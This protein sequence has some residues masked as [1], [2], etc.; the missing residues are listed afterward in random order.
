[1][2][3]VWNKVFLVQ[4]VLLV[5]PTILDNHFVIK[6]SYGF[7]AEGFLEDTFKS[8]KKHTSDAVDFIMEDFNILG[9]PEKKTRNDMYYTI[10]EIQKELS[11][12][13]YLHDRPDGIY[14]PKTKSAI[15]HFQQ[16]RNLPL[17]GNPSKELLYTLQS[18]PTHRSNEDDGSIKITRKPIQY[19]DR[20]SASTETSFT[21]IS[22]PSNGLIIHDRP[23]SKEH[24]RLLI[25]MV[26]RKFPEAKSSKDF[27]ES[28]VLTEPEYIQSRYFGKYGWKGNHMFEKEDSMKAYLHEH[29]VPYL[30]TLPELPIHYTSVA[31]VNLSDYREKDGGFPIQGVR[32]GPQFGTI[33]PYVNWQLPSIYPADKNQARAFLD[34]LEAQDHHVSAHS[35]FM[36]KFYF[37]V[38]AQLNDIKPIKEKRLGKEYNARYELIVKP[39]NMNLYAD[40]DL[41]KHVGGFPLENSLESTMQLAQTDSGFS[42]LLSPPG[43]IAPI[44]LPF[45]NGYPVFGEFFKRNHANL[46]HSKSHQRKFGQIEEGKKSAYRVNLGKYLDLLAIAD[47]PEALTVQDMEGKIKQ[48]AKPEKRHVSPSKEITQAE[49]LLYIKAKYLSDRKR[50][51]HI[52]YFPNY[53]EDGF[54]RGFIGKNIFEKEDNMMQIHQFLDLLTLETMGK[55]LP[56]RILHISTVGLKYN[57][58]KKGFDVTGRLPNGQMDDFCSN[59]NC[60]ISTALNVNLVKPDTIYRPVPDFFPME[61]LEARK[62]SSKLQ[63]EN[64]PYLKRD[65][66]LVW[67]IDLLHQQIGKPVS[68]KPVSAELYFDRDLTEKLYSFDLGVEQDDRQDFKRNKSSSEQYAKVQSLTTPPPGIEPISLSYI[69]GLPAFKPYNRRESGGGDKAENWRV[70][71]LKSFTNYITL[72][73]LAADQD[74]FSYNPDQKDGVHL[75]WANFLTTQEAKKYLSPEQKHSGH[76]TYK[77]WLGTTPFDQINSSRRFYDDYKSSLTQWA[78]LVF[79]EPAE[80]LHIQPVKIWNYNFKNQEFPIEEVS[81]PIQNLFKSSNWNRQYTWH[82]T[83]QMPEKWSVKPQE[84]AVANKKMVEYA[85]LVYLQRYGAKKATSSN[86]NYYRA[87]RALKVR[88]HPLGR[89]KNNGYIEVLSDGLYL[90]SQLNQKLTDFTVE[91]KQP[92]MLGVDS[93][94]HKQQKDRPLSLNADSINLLILKENG[95]PTDSNAWTQLMK[96]RRWLEYRSPQECDTLFFKPD[97]PNINERTNIPPDIRKDFQRWTAMRVENLATDLTLELVRKG[98]KRNQLPIPMNLF[99]LYDFPKA[100]K[101]KNPMETTI[102]IEDLDKNRYPEMIVGAGNISLSISPNMLQN[103]RENDAT[104]M[105]TLFQYIDCKGGRVSLKPLSTKL[106]YNKDILAEQQ[107]S[108]QQITDWQNGL[109]KRKQYLVEKYREG[110]SFSYQEQKELESFLTREKQARLK[111][112]RNKASLRKTGGASAIQKS[113]SKARKREAKKRAESLLGQISTVS[114]RISKSRDCAMWKRK[115]KGDVNASSLEVTQPCYF[116]WNEYTSPEFLSNHTVDWG[117]KGRPANP[118]SWYVIKADVALEDCK[119]SK[120]KIQITI[121]D[122]AVCQ[123]GYCFEHEIDVLYRQEEAESI[124]NTSY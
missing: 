59:P 46:N 83:Y 116:F 82:F 61:E 109:H 110:G 35:L 63:N 96:T 1:M 62:F 37:A 91:D 99:T 40:R 81:S 86:P 103:V 102:R 32:F 14:G 49:L 95:L 58:N 106:V 108:D 68:F 25:G 111:E 69:N 44:E 73:M 39:L 101:P 71:T 29:V 92:M 117:S 66:F 97:F 51:D 67:T 124:L 31:S 9:E 16:D 85:D 34:Q 78:K 12:L 123:E 64:N 27:L 120:G 107:F 105:R 33:A 75:F 77:K 55:N 104:E 30:T 53:F 56:R 113:K 4:I 80:V 48:L 87:Y 70:T 88:L 43:G 119:N 28:L 10:L 89:T 72:A 65:A 23:V 45:I 15:T 84:A 21:P 121:K 11:R 17:S 93:G 3:A 52:S 76:V 60:F 22:N 115:F 79:T 13:G 19:Q 50:R 41:N 47:N 26:M 2:R 90:D 6:R 20:Q 114:S 57:H 42:S 100:K 38:S 54:S 8:V 122:Y 36:R 118:N 74:L 18:T 24:Q 5:I 98:P 7:D 94:Q 112:E